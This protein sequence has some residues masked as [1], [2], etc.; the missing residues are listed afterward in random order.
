M[1]ADAS[2]TNNALKFDFSSTNNLNT[3]SVHYRQR[4]LSQRVTE[5]TNSNDILEWK[6]IQFPDQCCSVAM[7]PND[8]FLVAEC[9]TPFSRT[10]NSLIVYDLQ[11]NQLFKPQL[12]HL[13][14]AYSTPFY[15]VNDN[16]FCVQ[17]EQD[18]R[19]G[20][21]TIHLVDAITHRCFVLDQS[22][23][24][25]VFAV[26]N[27]QFVLISKNAIKCFKLPHQTNS[28]SVTSLTPYQVIS[29]DSRCAYKQCVKLQ[30]V[31]KERA[32]VILPM[33][34]SN[35]N[36]TDYDSMNDFT[37]SFWLLDLCSFTVIDMKDNDVF[38][39]IEGNFDGNSMNAPRVCYNKMNKDWNWTNDNSFCV[40]YDTESTATC[41]IYH[42]KIDL[43]EDKQYAIQCS[44]VRPIPK[45]GGGS[46]ICLYIRYVISILQFKHIQSASPIH[47]VTIR[48]HGIRM[49]MKLK[50]GTNAHKSIHKVRMVNRNDTST[51]HIER[52]MEMCY[53]ECCL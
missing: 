12:I 37:L 1:N 49:I 16:L 35:T 20:F 38:S 9:G 30:W 44:K 5:T 34:S 14:W 6:T 31:E 47:M 15:W 46:H 10:P 41:D 13:K 45:E 40:I 48:R 39:D 29:L 53:Q 17:S 23:G 21:M 51:S 24:G 27:K 28:D 50:D 4:I 7:S 43:L 8:R 2:I 52:L 26:N 3:D 19:T 22:S 32:V 36:G 42:C 25:E 11:T 33:M 18:Y